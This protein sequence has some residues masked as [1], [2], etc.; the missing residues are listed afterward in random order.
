MF[1][2]IVA[3]TRNSVGVGPW[4]LRLS[5]RFTAGLGERSYWLSQLA[6][7]ATATAAADLPTSAPAPWP[8]NRF[9]LAG[10]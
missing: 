7:A 3:R 6:G 10:C 8:Q 9:R 2:C 4:N 5:N 1:T